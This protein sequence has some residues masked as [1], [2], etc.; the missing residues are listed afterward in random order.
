[1][2]VGPSFCEPNI[3]IQRSQK[4]RA[5]DT[6]GGE[7]AHRRKRSVYEDRHQGSNPDARA[8]FAARKPSCIRC[9][10]FYGTIAKNGCCSRCWEEGQKERSFPFRPCDIRGS[11]QMAAPPR[12]SVTPVAVLSQQSP[13]VAAPT[14]PSSGPSVQQCDLSGGEPQI[15]DGVQALEQ[16]QRLPL[17]G[18]LLDG[19]TIPGSTAAAQGGLGMV[20]HAGGITQNVRFS[21]RGPSPQTPTLPTRP[22][23]AMFSAHGHRLTW[24]APP[25]IRHADASMDMELA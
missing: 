12:P 14:M 23:A 15:L 9:D 16:L 2:D 25:S 21:M 13:I 10:K 20:P 24:S 18:G 8:R 6:G 19:S 4:R 17:V 11:E 1:V 22:E 7:V 3:N 5:D